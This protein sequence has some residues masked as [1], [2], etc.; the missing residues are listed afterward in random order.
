M[1]VCPE[2][3]DNLQ[4]K[5]LTTPG[6][7]AKRPEPPTFPVAYAVVEAESKNARFQQRGDSEKLADEVPRRWLSVFGGEAVAPDSASGRK[8]LAEWVSQ[9]SLTARVMANRIWEWHF[10]SVL[11]RSSNDFGARGEP[12]T[13][14]EL[15]DWLSAKFVAGGYN[16]K[17]MHRLIM[18]TAAYQRASAAP[19]PGDP[20]NRWLA[21]ARVLR[22]SPDWEVAHADAAAILLRRRTVD[23]AALPM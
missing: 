19:C 12:P 2:S 7:A 3:R 11:V 15:L 6:D 23:L 18:N 13:H 9:S 14:P 10:G 17:T 16:V 22:E 21:L 1:H 8:Q 5:T 4:G 20:D